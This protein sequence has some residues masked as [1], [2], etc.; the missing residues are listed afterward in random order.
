MISFKLFVD[1]SLQIYLIFFSPERYIWETFCNF[2]HF[3]SFLLFA[4]GGRFFFF[5]FCSALICVGGAVV[6]LSNLSVLL[7]E[8]R[9]KKGGARFYLLS[10]NFHKESSVW[11]AVLFKHLLCSVHHGENRHVVTANPGD[12]MDKHAVGSCV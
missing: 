6:L 7:K 12:I 9:K 8:K 4:H 2:W 10:F 3:S 11:P 1:S 5:F